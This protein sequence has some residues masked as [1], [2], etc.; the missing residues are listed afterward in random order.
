MSKVCFRCAFWNITTAPIKITQVTND[1]LPATLPTAGT[2]HFV[3]YGDVAAA[4]SC[5]ELCWYI[6]KFC[7]HVRWMLLNAAYEMHAMAGLL[8]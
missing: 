4:F 5:E 6:G 7:V 1:H 3:K 8:T 2:S